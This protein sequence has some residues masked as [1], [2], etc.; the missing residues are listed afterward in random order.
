MIE[1]IRGNGDGVNRYVL[2]V[3]C[4]LMVSFFE[5]LTVPFVLLYDCRKPSGLADG[6]VERAKG[7]LVRGGKP[8]KIILQP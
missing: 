4:Y 1:D 6:L 2:F 8:R 5:T 7:E 3:K